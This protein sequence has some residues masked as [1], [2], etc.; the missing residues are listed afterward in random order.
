MLKISKALKFII[1]LSL[2][3]TIITML[4]AFNQSF[5]YAAV[6]QPAG[7]SV[8]YILIKAI[9][10]D[11]SRAINSAAITINKRIFLS[12]SPSGIIKVDISSKELSGFDFLD[13]Q[14][15]REGYFDESLEISIKDPSKIAQPVK[16]KMKQKMGTL[17]GVITGCWSDK[18]GHYKDSYSNE[19]IKVFGK[20]LSSQHIIYKFKSDAEGYFKIFNLPVGTY[21][22][23]IRH[24]QWPVSV[25]KQGEDISREFSIRKCNREQYHKNDKNPSKDKDGGGTSKFD[26]NESLNQKD[27][28]AVKNYLKIDGYN[29]KDKKNTEKT[30]VKN[31]DKNKSK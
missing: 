15:K 17:S 27:G 22:I 12:T 18:D 5:V 11:S 20:A 7:Q 16:I 13:I 25:E 23:E 2:Y 1:R 14:A 24:K 30:N 29:V 10:T 31:G 21:E 4:P 9:D 8:K 6:K 26:L 28:G 19:E 3:V